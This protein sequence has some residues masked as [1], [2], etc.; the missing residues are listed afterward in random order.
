MNTK[1]DVDG[2]AAGGDGALAATAA[3]GGRSSPNYMESEVGRTRAALLERLMELLRELSFDRTNARTLC[4]FA[5][6]TRMIARP[7]LPAAPV[8]RIILN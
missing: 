7:V 3:S 4:F 6:K 8:T 2:A 5:A 1:K